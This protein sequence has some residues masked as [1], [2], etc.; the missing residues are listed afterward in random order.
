M[1]QPEHEQWRERF[2]RQR[3]T[4]EQLAELRAANPDAAEAELEAALSDAL[5]RLPDAPVPSN[6]T[7]RV[8]Q[9][10]ERETMPAAP[11]PRD[12]SWILRVLLPRTAVAAAVVGIGLLAFR[13]H[14]VQQANRMADSLRAVAAVQ[15]V[16][17]P[18][19]LENFDVIEKLDS[20][21]AADRELIALLQ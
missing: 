17:S 7:A 2:W 20:N 5:A 11:R 8:L 3:L 6:F 15:I 4:Q 13:Q 14:E 16:P 12:W 10:I 9:G 1:N 19:A 18:D 21:P